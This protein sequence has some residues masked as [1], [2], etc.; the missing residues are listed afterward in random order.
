[1]GSIFVDSD[2]AENSIAKTEKKAGT[3][4]ETLG[5][6]I[7]TAGKWGLTIGAAAGGA[8]LAVGALAKPLVES[9]AKASAMN[10]QFEQ[11]FGDMQKSLSPL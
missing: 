4:G 6:G 9:A 7:K 2:A 1:M 8:A 3:M 10:A 5:K 11:V